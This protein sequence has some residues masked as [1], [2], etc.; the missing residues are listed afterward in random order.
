V[1]TPVTLLERLRRGNDTEAWG[2]FVELY[3]PLLYY[4]L[5]RT[6]L[7]QAD[8]ADLVQEVLILLFKKLPEFHY[9]RRQSFRAWLR[10]VTLNRWRESRRR[11]GP[12]ALEAAEVAAP[13]ELGALEEVE[14]R[15]H[16]VQRGLRVLQ[17]EFS[18]TTWTAFH[19]HV[20]AGRDAEDVA[21]QLGVRIGTV[22]AAKS[23]VL[24]RLRQELQGLLD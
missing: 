23:R 9:D 4:W 24:A 1:E 15:R 6:G 14:Y 11:A 16:L 20:M 19:E 5:R 8:T 3:T 13:D 2:R 7:Q 18:A 22:Y 10:T 12:V 21:A 17:G